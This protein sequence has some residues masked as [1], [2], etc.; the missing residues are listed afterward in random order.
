METLP[1]QS[2]FSHGRGRNILIGIGNEYRGDDALGILVAREIARRGLPGFSVLEQSGEGTNL[3]DAWKDARCV[4]IIDAVSSSATPGDLHR[5]DASREVIPKRLFHYSSHAFGVAEAIEMAR[6]LGE[7]PPVA[8]LYGIE[9][10]TFEAGIGLSESVIRQIPGL[11]AMIFE[12]LKRFQF[13]AE[14]KHEGH[15]E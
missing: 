9:G 13:N 5:L 3:M 1:S 8:I 15:N 7:L 4:M 11:I 12:D 6:A 2:G 14:G 10:E